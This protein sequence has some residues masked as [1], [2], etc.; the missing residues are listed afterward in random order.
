MHTLEG[1]SAGVRSMP[2][3]TE[4]RQQPR[5]ALEAEVT[6]ESESNFYAGFTENVS[7]GGIF[8][9]TYA[10]HSV[11]ERLRVRFTLPGL[12]EAIEA[13]CEVRWLRVQNPTSDTPPGVGLRFMDLSDTAR[14]NIERF[15]RARAPIFFE[16]D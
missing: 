3:G 16:E 2:E 9:A 8:V 4:R 6:L 10:R 13:T 7:E 11:G 1:E 14:A 15:V 5:V 12:S